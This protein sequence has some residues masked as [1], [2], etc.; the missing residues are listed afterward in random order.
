MQMSRLLF[1]LLAVILSFATYPVALM[2]KTGLAAVNGD[3]DEITSVIKGAVEDDS[4]LYLK[5]EEDIEKLLSRYYDGDLLKKLTRDA[6]KF[7]SKSTD[8]YSRAKLVSV[9][10]KEINSLNTT[11]EAIL[12]VED[13]I[14]GERQ[15]GKAVY[16]LDRGKGGWRVT[17]VCYRWTAEV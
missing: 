6:W 13:V 11:A 9:V 5:T 14:S 12:E 10:V 1:L 7:N 16:I 8:W 17:N 2:E 15:R 3:S 4:W